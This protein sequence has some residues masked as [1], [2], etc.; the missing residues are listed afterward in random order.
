MAIPSLYSAETG[1]SAI[2]ELIVK[3]G[4]YSTEAYLG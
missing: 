4:I 1:G 3:K 2:K